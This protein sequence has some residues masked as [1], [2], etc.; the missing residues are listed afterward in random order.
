MKPKINYDQKVNI[1]NLRLSKKKSVD[2]DVQGN[3]VVDYDA[4]GNIV[5]IEIMDFSIEEFSKVKEFI[6]SG[7]LAYAK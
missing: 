2:S 5:N 3:V 7:E 4:K 6:H 1:L